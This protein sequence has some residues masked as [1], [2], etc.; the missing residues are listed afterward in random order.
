[1]LFGFF[2]VFLKETQKLTAGSV[3]HILSH[4]LGLLFYIYYPT[5]ENVRCSKWERQDKSS[6]YETERKKVK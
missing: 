2:V 3:I 1:V 5:Q 6:S 4:Q